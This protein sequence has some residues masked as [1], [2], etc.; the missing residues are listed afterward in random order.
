M[1]KAEFY[2]DGSHLLTGFELF[3]HTGYG[4]CG[5]D[6]VCAAISALTQ[7]AANGITEVLGLKADI[8][9]NEETGFL[10]VSVPEYRE[11]GVQVLLK[12]LRF[13]LDEIAKDY[14]GTIRIIFR[15]RR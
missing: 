15:E 11:S 10:S 9:V 8:R 4:E 7:A 1:T 2:E 3:G 6:I 5:S 13:S 12:T 14:P